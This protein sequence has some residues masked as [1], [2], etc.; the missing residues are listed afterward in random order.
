MYSR[1]LAVN[2]LR[3][4]SDSYI[5]PAVQPLHRRPRGRQELEAD[6]PLP[7]SPVEQCSH[8]L[9]L[10][11]YGEHLSFMLLSIFGCFC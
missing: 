6:L 10:L 4:F 1:H 3:A 11:V 5:G 8:F 7:R 9:F 2:A